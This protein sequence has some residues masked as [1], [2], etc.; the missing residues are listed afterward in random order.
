MDREILE[1]LEGIKR[2]VTQSLAQANARADVAL[3]VTGL[4]LAADAQRDRNPT[5]RLEQYLSWL[6]AHILRAQP[7]DAE[8]AAL[9][10][11]FHTQ[12]MDDLRRVAESAQVA[13][14]NH[15]Q[16]KRGAATERPD[17]PDPR[18]GE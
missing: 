9:T 6:H 4:L 2:A 12:A 5:L 18:S 7:E 16:R 17:D 11:P 1:T 13:L 14:M 15:D 3:T 8:T 10:A